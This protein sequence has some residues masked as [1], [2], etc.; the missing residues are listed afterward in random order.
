ML[1][2]LRRG[3]TVIPLSGGGT[4][5]GCTY[6]PRTPDLDEQAVTSILRDGGDVAALARRNVTESASV[7]LTGT[8]AAILNQ[9]RAL[10][11]LFPV[12]AAARRP[13]SERVYLEFR[14]QDS[15]DIYRSEILTGRVEWPSN[16]PIG[17]RLLGGAVEVTLIWQRR[18]FWEDTTLRAVPLS[19]GNGNNVTGGL[20][21]Y[22]H[23]DAGSGHDNYVDIGASAVGGVIPAPAR[24]RLVNISG[25]SYGLRNLY[26]GHNVQ[27]SPSALNPIVEAE[28][29]HLAGSNINDTSASNG[30]YRRVNW[31]GDSDTIGFG[32]TLNAAR[33]AAAKGHAFRVLARFASTPA[34]DIF[35]RAWI[36]YPPNI[37]VTELESADEVQLGGAQLV[38]LGLLHLPPVPLDSSVALVLALSLRSAGGG[39][40]ELDF[41]QLTALDSWR[42]LQQLGYQISVGDAVVDDGVAGIVYGQ[43]PDGDQIPIYNAFGQPVHLWPNAQQRLMFLWDEG[44]NMNI[45]RTF[46]V[47]VHVRPRRLTV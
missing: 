17:P 25:V 5:A 41:V 43:E 45:A 40:V 28:S 33:L 36:G 4:I 16:V 47:Q 31:A 1:V 26:I 8:A 29:S 20:T 22:N 10:E 27:A 37:P 30:S 11:A 44:S 19:N 14:V 34:S 15:G 9:V 24:L 13:A 7:I 6:V 23:N 12:E 2:R 3:S 35:A 46:S 42:H 21:V 39:T 18:Y 38:D 32:W